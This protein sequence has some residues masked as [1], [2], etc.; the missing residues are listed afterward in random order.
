MDKRNYLIANA[1][2]GNKNNEPAIEFAY[3][4]PLLKFK[5]INVIL[6]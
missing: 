6:L 5:E 3:Q 1:L 4:G 2:V